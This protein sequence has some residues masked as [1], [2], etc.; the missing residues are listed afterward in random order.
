MTRVGSRAYRAIA[1]QPMSRRKKPPGQSTPADRAVREFARLAEARR[2]R[3]RVQHPAAVRD[4]PALG[5]PGAGMEDLHPR[6]V[7]LAEPDRLAAPVVAR[8]AVGRQH[9]GQR[10]VGGEVHPRRRRARRSRRRGRR[11]AAAPRAASPA[12]APPGRRSGRCTRRAAARRPR[13]SARHRARPGTASPAG[14]SPRASAGRCGRA[15]PRSPPASSPAPA[16]RRPCRRC[17]GP[18]RRRR[19]A[20]GPGRCRGRPGPRRRP[21]RR[22]SPPRRPSPPRSPPARRRPR[23]RSRRAPPCAAPTVAATVTPLPA[24]SPS[25][26]TTIGAPCAST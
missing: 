20:C 19:R 23:G 24:A 2:P 26:F 13:S 17:S 22:G 25:A 8:I 5:E 1:R 11:R 14:P 18:R 12:P 9:H 4:Q 21:A 16:S 15:P 10:M 7:A 6:V 3:G